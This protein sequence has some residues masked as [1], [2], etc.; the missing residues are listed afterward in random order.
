M[1]TE[2]TSEPREWNLSLAEWR[3]AMGYSPADAA[4]FLGCVVHRIHRLE[5][6]KGS[7][8]LSRT[9]RIAMFTAVESHIKKLKSIVN[10][11]EKK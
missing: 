8:R 6:G 11:E 4:K 1:N 3:Q 5:N 2:N 7:Y 10:W 9:D